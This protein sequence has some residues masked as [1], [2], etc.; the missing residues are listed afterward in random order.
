[1]TSLLSGDGK[2]D[3]PVTPPASQISEY[4]RPIKVWP[5][6]PESTQQIPD[7]PPPDPDGNLIIHINTVINYFTGLFGN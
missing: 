2:K 6:L 4:V 5:P 1:M 3:E 7:Q